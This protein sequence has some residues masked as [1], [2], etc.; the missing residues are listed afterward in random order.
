M[1]RKLGAAFFAVLLTGGL[2]AARVTSAAPVRQATPAATAPFYLHDGDTVVF[3]GDSITE[4]QMYAR[5]IET[6]VTTR[7]P[8]MHVKFINSGWSGD[9]IRGG[10]GGGIDVRLKRDV[11]NYKPTVV[12]VF[13]GM[14]DGRYRSY[15]D[16]D[17]QTY[18][19]GMT[20]I[21]D[22]LTKALPG[23]R[24]TLLTPSFFDYNAKVRPAFDPSTHI[25]L[26]NPSPDYNDTLVKYGT[27]LKQLAAQRQMP[28]ADLNA[29]LEAA[30]TEGRA[31][32]PK[33][34]LSPEG[35][36]PNEVG[37]LIMAAAVLQAWHAPATV[38][39][40]VVTPGKP[41]TAAAP[42]PWPVPNGARAAF[43]VSP[44]PGALDVFR[45][46]LSPAAHAGAG[47]QYQ[48]LVDGHAYGTVTADGAGAVDADLTTFPALP[49]NRQAQ[50]V[51]GLVQTRVD[52]WHLFWRG[53][54]GKPGVAQLTDVPTDDEL[55]RLRAGDAALDP[56]RVQA[57]DAAQ[58]QT[59]TYELLPVTAH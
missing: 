32:D 26:G 9:K 42:L 17:F 48:V 23:V 4:Q 46:R 28:V 52:Q 55:S 29:P 38:A 50:E 37:H 2:W 1:R 27:F 18:S 56:Q 47:A 12:T 36:H 45:L 33:F 16:P 8:Q 20:H 43:R 13:L 40:L 30:T 25:G 31:A 49:Q 59:H 53:V 51:Y 41:V 19:A 58:P 44:L 11:I 22:T 15:D 21:L 6:Y 3:Y 7:F 54:G 24:I 35:V 39:D 57:R 14:N 5:D 10:T 34:A